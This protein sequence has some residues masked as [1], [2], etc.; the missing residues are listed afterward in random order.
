MSTETLIPTDGMAKTSLWPD[1]HGHST[2]G[3]KHVTKGNDTAL[4][5]PSPI[6]VV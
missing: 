4:C 6:D 5:M 1:P 3:A 2:A